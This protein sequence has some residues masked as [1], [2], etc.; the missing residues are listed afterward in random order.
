MECIIDGKYKLV[1]CIEVDIDMIIAYNDE[2]KRYGENCYI[3]WLLDKLGADGWKEKAV[4]DNR[5]VYV[6]FFCCEELIGIGRIT[7]PLTYEA[8]GVLGY[9]IRPT[10]RG[11]GH[12][13]VMIEMMRRMCTK[14]GLKKITACIDEKNTRSI[15]AIESAHWKTTGRVF[16]WTDS[17]KAIEYAPQKQ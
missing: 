4:N 3:L 8:N 16:D 15:K 14:I 1:N 13:R 12:A 10:K 6:G 11:E 17:R 5:T 7:D 9:A 2:F